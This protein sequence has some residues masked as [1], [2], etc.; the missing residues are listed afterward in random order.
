VN[1][2]AFQFSDW[3]VKVWD[4]PIG[5]ARGATLTDAQRQVLATHLTAHVTPDGFL[6]LDPQAPLANSVTDTPDARLDAQNNSIGIIFRS[7]TDAE[8]NGVPTPQGYIATDGAPGRVLCDPRV[9]LVVWLAGSPSFRQGAEL[10]ELRK[11]TGPLPQW[12]Q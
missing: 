9:P 5:D 8:Q 6:V 12:H 1:Y 11:L 7:C 10:L 4:Y 3:V 2:L